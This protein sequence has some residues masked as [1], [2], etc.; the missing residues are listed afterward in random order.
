M[1]LS[2]KVS[3]RRNWD[4][5]IAQTK[6]FIMRKSKIGISGRMTWLNQNVSS[7]ESLKTRLVFN[8]RFELIWIFGRGFRWTLLENRKRVAFF[9]E[10]SYKHGCA[11]C[12]VS[13]SCFAVRQK[14]LEKAKWL[15][16]F[17]VLFFVFGDFLILYLPV[18]QDVFGHGSQRGAALAFFFRATKVF[19]G[20]LSP[21]LQIRVRPW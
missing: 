15:P 10:S 19:R 9:V 21:T 5:D 17:V 20:E 4:G 1:F 8:L 2:E 16:T 3:N 13:K 14:K 6:C 18:S 12:W 11:I 7:W